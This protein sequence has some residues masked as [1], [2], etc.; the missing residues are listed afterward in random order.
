MIKPES[1]PEIPK[2]K[3]GVLLVNLGTP[4]GTDYFSMR[5]YLKEFLS[6]RRVIEVPKVLWSPILNLFILTFRPSKSGKLYKKIWDKKKNQ[7]PLRVNTEKQAKK[8][9]KGLKK[10][11]IIVD[12]AM[13]YGNPSIDLKIKKL[14][15]Q[16][17]TKILILPMYPQYSATTTASVMDKVYETLKELRWQ[18]TLRTV[19]P[20]F[21]DDAYIN[22][23]VK[24]IDNHIEK[25]SWKPD[26]I[27]CSF[28]GLPKKYFLKGDPYHCHCAKTK[29]LIKEKLKRKVKNVE[30]CFQ[31]RFGP[32]EWLRPYMN[33]KFKDI[34]N[35]N[36]KK[37][38]MI[39]PG[40]S[41]D[42]LETLEEIAMEGKEEFMEMGGTHYSYIPCLNDSNESISLIKKLVLK[43]LKGWI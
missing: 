16:G 28:H 10:P 34:L 38:C 19:E 5:R 12:W 32:Q 22:A 24:T 13:R 15:T 30:L 9:A 17:C 39:A 8:L 11:S 27:V 14:V 1:H 25:L 33:E 37:I 23:I 42:C 18:P 29:R 6:D 20:Y 31:S 4:D 2:A 35:K 41:S 7:S 21:D 40:F 36:Q 3:T 26:T 43:N